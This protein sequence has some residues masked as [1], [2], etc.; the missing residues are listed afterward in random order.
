MHNMYILSVSHFQTFPNDP[1]VATALRSCE[2]DDALWL[3]LTS[4]EPRCGEW[5]PE[6]LAMALPEAD[7]ELPPL[8]TETWPE[9]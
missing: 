6:P 4:V 5:D 3:V 7:P 1:L 9:G 2:A 8:G